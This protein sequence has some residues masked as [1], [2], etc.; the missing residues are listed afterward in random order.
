MLIDYH[1]HIEK[2]PYSKKRLIQYLEVG[3]KRGV[4]EFCITEH[5]HQFREVK[6]SLLKS[7]RKM[8]KTDIVDT[9]LYEHFTQSVEEYINFIESIKKEGYPIKVGC[10]VDYFEGE[11]KWIQ[12]FIETYPWDFILG[13]VHWIKGLPASIDNPDYMNLWK[14]KVDN[15]YKTYF[16]LI[17]KAVL[18]GLFDAISHL[19]LV[20]LFGFR[21]TGNIHD[22]IEDTI[23]TM[24]DKNIG[25]ELNT[26]G[27]RRPV[28]EMY[29]SMEILKL[30]K[31]YG[32][33][34]T[35]GSDAHRPE[36]VGKDFD[37]ALI[38]LKNA[39]YDKLSTFENRQRR[40]VPIF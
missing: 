30:C 12:S 13:S 24:T 34:I 39:G 29:P 9:W 25:T 23:A 38:I 4:K 27:L 36:D 31:N 15:T 40:N 1:I 16:S 22:L 21:P 26:A 20:K 32:V 7:V 33:Y 19:D 18:S 2:T 10:E 35:L 3:F 37:K 28:N 5:I 6:S 17:K 14:D 8:V 11:E